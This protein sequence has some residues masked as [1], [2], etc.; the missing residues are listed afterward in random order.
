M[1]RIVKEIIVVVSLLVVI[2]TQQTTAQVTEAELL[3]PRNL[4]EEAS[5]RNEYKS[6]II[7][8]YEYLEQPTESITVYGNG[9]SFLN[10]KTHDG[11]D[12]YRIT[13]TQVVTN[14]LGE[15]VFSEV[16]EDETIYEPAIPETYT[17]GVQPQVGATFSPRF[18][19]YGADCVLCTHNGDGT[20]TAASGIRVGTTSVR[21][22]DGTFKQGITYDGRYLFATSSH[23]P[24][25]TLIS[26]ENHNYEGMG[27][28]QDEPILGFIGDRGVGPNHLDLFA[29]SEHALNVVS[30]VNDNTPIVTITGFGTWANGKC[31]F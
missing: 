25:C 9:L 27:I 21:Q 17:Q 15:V 26:I 2:P 3:Q 11:Q 8:E 31:L 4:I 18:T 24:M 7:E 14:G 28:T 29:G 12:G 30:V 22:S 5:L 1:K 20:S 10:A 23:I 13:Y 16:I 6:E 19:R